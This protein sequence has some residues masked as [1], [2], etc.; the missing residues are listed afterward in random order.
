MC[1][2][3]TPDVVATDFNPLYN[4]N[5]VSSILETTASDGKTY[6]IV[7]AEL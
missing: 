7:S 4:E 5:S 3:G 6:Q 2:V 1:P